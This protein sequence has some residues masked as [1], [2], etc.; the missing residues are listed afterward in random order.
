MSFLVRVID[1]I[2]VDA[3]PESACLVR[4]D[5]LAMPPHFGRVLPRTRHRV[6]P[7]PS[8][9]APPSLAQVPFASRVE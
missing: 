4:P 7:E 9:R 3:P 8:Q 2:Y 6:C 1:R 5:L